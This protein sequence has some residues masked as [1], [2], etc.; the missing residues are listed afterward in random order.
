MSVRRKYEIESPEALN[1]I[2]QKCL[3][4]WSGPQIVLLHGAL[5]TGKTTL[6]QLFARALGSRDEVSSPTYA[7][8]QE[9]EGSNE[10]IYHV[11]LY[12]LED[13]LELRTEIGLDE[14]LDNGRWVFIEWPD[15]AEDLLQA[16]EVKRIKIEHRGGNSRN[17]IVLDNESQAE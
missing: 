5:G 15:L 1:D 8:I 16:Y 17:I 10:V 9:Y 2:V 4:Y 12:R 6:V 13:P 3:E 14:V 11:D 7:L